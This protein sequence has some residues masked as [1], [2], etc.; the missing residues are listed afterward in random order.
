MNE[1]AD[2]CKKARHHPE[3]SNVYNVVFVRWTTHHESKGVTER[4]VQMAS[5]CDDVAER[6]GEVG[7]VAGEGGAGEGMERAGGGRQGGGLAGLADM[8]GEGG[9]CCGGK[10]KSKAR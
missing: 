10:A 3:W 9:E 8:A 5:F 7:T 1:V 2:E 4:D 6:L